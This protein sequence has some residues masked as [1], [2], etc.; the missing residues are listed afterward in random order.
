MS[1]IS[2]AC[3]VS[4]GGWLAHVTVA[5]RG[6]TRHYEV[7]VSSAE[8]ARFAPGTSEPSDLVRRSFEFLLVREP[9]ESI[10]PAFDLSVI[11][12]Y[13]PEYERT[14]RGSAAGST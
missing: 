11:G 5:D 3:S 4:G 1:G 12:R 6:S 7:R 14:I 8:L 2:V 10:L 9:K 13:Y